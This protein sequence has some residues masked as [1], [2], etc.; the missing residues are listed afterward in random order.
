MIE[1]RIRHTDQSNAVRLM[2]WPA[3]DLE[4][5]M[6]AVSDWS[7]RF[8][9]GTEYGQP[10]SFTGQLVAE[11]GRAYFEILVNDDIEGPGA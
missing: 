8:E 7:V 10:E 1:V 3:N 5:A 2:D 9:D 11:E 4:S 6:R